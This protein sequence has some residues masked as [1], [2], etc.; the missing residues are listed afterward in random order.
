[1][2]RSCVCLLLA[3]FLAGCPEEAAPPGVTGGGAPDTTVVPDT[4]QRFPGLDGQQQRYFD[5]GNDPA[6]GDPGGGP[7]PGEDAEPGV[8]AWVD[9][10]FGAPCVDNSD[11]D[12]G[13]CVKGPDD[14]YVCTKLCLDECPAGWLCKGAPQTAPDVLFIC[15]FGQ[16]EP[17]EPCGYDEECGGTLDRCSAIGNK[18]ETY[19][20]QH[21]ANAGECPD[22]FTC[23]APAARAGASV[24]QCIPDTN[25][26][27]C[28]AEL[29]QT[30]RICEVLNQFGVCTGT[31]LCDGADGWIGCTAEPPAPE[32]CDGVDN[33]CDGDTDEGFPPEPC[34]IENAYGKCTGVQA[35]TG[36]GGVHCDAAI[37]D[38]ELCDGADNDCDGYTDQGFTDTEGDG[39]ADCVDPDDDDDDVKDAADNCPLK[40]NNAQDDLDTDGVGDLCDDDVDGDGIFNVADNCPKIFNPDQ[41]DLDADTAGD[42]CDPDIDGDGD[43][44]ETDCGPTDPLVSQSGKEACDGKDNDCDGLFDEGFTDTDSDKLGDCIDPDDDNDGEP[45]QTDCEPLDPTVYTGADELCDQKDNDCDDLVDEGFP[46]LDGNGVLDCVETDG[47]G[48]G[49]PDGTDC[50]PLDK[51]IHHAADELCDGLD[52]DCDGLKDEDFPDSDGDLLA[53]CVDADDDNDG[54]PDTSDCAPLD[55]TVSGKVLE[56]CNG[57]DDN[58]NELVDEG[59]PDLDGDGVANCADADDDNDG[60]ADGEDNCPFVKN[61]EQGDNDV[62]GAGDLCDGDDDNDGVDDDVDNCPL[63]ANAPQGDLDGNGEGDACDADD[64]GD[65]TPDSEDCKPKNALVHKGAAEVCDGLDNNCDGAADE[66]FDDSDEDSIADCVDTDDDNDGDPDI[67]DC[68]P[69]DP[70]VSNLSL[71]SCNGKDDNCNGKVDE[72]F[73]DSDLD[74]VPDCVDTDDDDDGDVDASD[75]APTDPDVHHGA[76]EI[77]NGKDDNCEDG[78]DEGFVDSD[79]DKLPDCADDDD[80]NDG[81]PDATDCAPLDQKVSSLILEI[82]DGKDN[83]CNGAADEGFDDTDGDKQADCVDPDDDGDGMEDGADC[84]PKDPKVFGGAKELCDGKDNDCNGKVD[85]GF[86]DSDG[87]G[88]ADCVDADSDNDGDPDVTDCA[89]TDP[90]ISSLLDELC[91]GKDNNCQGGADESFPDTDQDG[92][93]DCVDTDDDND[94]VPDAD[95]NCG[96]IKNPKQV[97]SDGDGQGD[98]CDTDSDNDGV[99]NGADNCVVVFNPGQT[100]TDVDGMGDA[101]DDDDDGDTVVDTADCEPLIA[102]IF[103]GAT[104]LCDDIDNDCDGKVDEGFGDNDDDGQ[105]DCLDPDDDNDGD[106]DNTDCEPLDATVSH[107][108]KEECDNV[109]NNCDGQVDEGFE[110]PDKDGIASCVDHDDDGDGVPDVSDNCSTVKN[111]DQSDI[112]GDGLG[113][114]CDDDD[115]NDGTPDSE[116]CNTKNAAVAPGKAE[117][118]DGIDNDCDGKADEDFPDT[119]KDGVADCLDKDDDGDGDPDVNDCAPLDA[120]ISGDAKEL[121]DGLDNNCNDAIDEGFTD[122]DGDSSPDCLDNDDDNDGD[123]DT[124]DCAPLDSGVHHGAKELCNALDDNCVD[125]VDEGFPSSDADALPDCLDTDDD[126]DGDPDATDC[127]PLNA[128]ISSLVTEACDGKDNNCDGKIDEGFLDTDSDGTADCVDADDDGDTVPDKDDCAPK[129]ATISAKATEVCDGKDNNC[130][131]S[132]DEGFPD[133]DKDGQADCVDLDDDNDGDPDDSDCDDS[134]PAIS[135]VATELCDGKDNNC[136]GK[137]DEGFPNADGDPLADCVDGDDDND[138]TPDDDDNC[139]TKANDQTDTDA[140]GKGDACD[141]DDDNDGLPDPSDNCPLLANPLQK[142]T[143]NDKVGDQCDDDD[144]NDGSKDADDC[145]PLDGAIHPGATEICDGVDQDCDGTVDEGFGNFDGDTLGD[146][147]DPDDDNDLDPDTSDCQPKNPAIHA[148][149]LEVCDGIDQNC[150]GV[151]DDGFPDLNK[152]G[153]ADCV[154]PDDDGDDKLDGDDNCPAVAN[155]DQADN[156][157]DGVGDACDSDDDNDDLPDGTDNCPLV[158]NP[159]QADNDSDKVGDACDPDDDNDGYDDTADCKPLDKNVNPGVVEVCD[160]IDNSCAGVA[161]KGFPDLDKDG[162]ADCVDNDDDGDG[163]PDSNDCK[164]LDNKIYNGAPELCDG[165]DNNCNLQIDE[166]HLDTDGDTIADCVD[167]DDDGDGV[168][169]TEDNCQLVFNPDQV[170]IDEDGI[171]DTCDPKVPGVVTKVVIRDAAK[172]KGSEVGDV[173]VELGETLTLYAA[174]YDKDGLFAGGQAV[175]WSVDG[176]LDAVSAAADE[177][178]ATFAPSTPV[179]SGTIIASPKTAGVKSDTTGTITVN[180]PPP[181]CPADLTKTTIVPQRDSIV[182]DG[183]DQVRVDVVTRD[184]WGSPVDCEGD[185][186]VLESTAGTL[187]ASVTDDGTVYFQNLQSEIVTG[188][189]T[190]SGTL[191]G[192]PITQTATVEFVQPE[193]VVDG[194]ATIDCSNYNAFEGKSILVKDGGTLT[195]LCT[196]E[197]PLM[198]FGSFFIKHGTL[199]T[200]KG[201]RINIQVDEMFIDKKGVVTVAQMGPTTGLATPPDIAS[202]YEIFG[203]FTDPKTSGRAGCVDNNTGYPGGLLRIKVVGSGKFTL[204]GV[205]DANAKLN[206]SSGCYAGKPSSF[207][208]YLGSSGGRVKISAKSL[209]GTGTITSRGNKGKW[210]PLYQPGNGGVISLVDFE[211]RS[212]SFA[213]PAIYSQLHARPGNGAT[214][215]PGAAPGIVYLRPKGQKYGDIIMGCGTGGSHAGSAHINTVPEATVTSVTSN[216]IV[217]SGAGWPVDRYVGLYVNPNIAQGNV[218]DKSDDV[219]FRVVKNT[220]DTLFLDGNPTGV[221]SAGDTLRGILPVRNLEIRGRATFQTTGD[222]MVAEGDLHSGDTVTFEFEG[223]FKAKDLDL[224]S[225]EAIKVSGPLAGSATFGSPL[226]PL[227]ANL[228]Y[229]QILRGGTDDFTFN[230]SLASQARLQTSGQFRAGTLDLTGNGKVI[231]ETGV[232]VNSTLS[233]TGGHIESKG[234][235]VINGPV[236]IASFGGH[237]SIKVPKADWA[238]QQLKLNGVSGQVDLGATKIELPKVD[239][240][241]ATGFKLACYRGS[242]NQV[243]CSSSSRLE[244]ETLSR[245]GDDSYAFDMDFYGV[246]VLGMAVLYARD[247]TF[248]GGFQKS[249]NTTNVLTTGAIPMPNGHLNISGHDNTKISVGVESGTGAI[250]AKSVSVTAGTHIATSLTAATTVVIGSTFDVG[251]VAAGGNMTVDVGGFLTTESLSTSADLFVQ[252]TSTITH[253]PA[254]DTTVY[255][256]QI[257]AKSATIAT[258]SNINLNRRGFQQGF[259]VGNTTTGGATGGV[260][261]S[262]GGLGGLGLAGGTAPSVFDDPEAPLLPGGGGGGPLSYGGGQLEMTLTGTLTVNGV[263]MANGKTIHEGG[264]AGGAIWIKGAKTITGGGGGLISAVGGDAEDPVSGGGGG[265]RIALTGYTTLSGNFAPGVLDANI[266]VTGGTGLNDGGDGTIHLKPAP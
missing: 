161:D 229:E 212:G 160:G 70:I 109:D 265:G 242:T 169:D 33:D 142:D 187:V 58:C 179:T 72:G 189:A 76:V 64:D 153:Q 185:V 36:E 1:M 4:E 236:A 66:G 244:V 39:I 114:A 49:D 98:A 10:G 131:G 258:G 63:N 149:A 264:G 180:A 55:K 80:D 167:P 119:D 141:P 105:G 2:R 68:A 12:S 234:D 221:A 134:N 18:G 85:D 83:N 42:L 38:V 139:P 118:C 54:D 146:C 102:A 197:C 74:T 103:P 206:Y 259:T 148:S 257:S 225:V 239:F 69:T 115:D 125:G 97:D 73:P 254:S 183:I 37:P 77:C 128:N 163:D 136:N 152:D 196:D 245:Q 144:D 241:A 159:S 112:D 181:T 175:T 81:D 107:F 99:G 89:P 35:C 56:S 260:G 226:V 26:C 40:A 14:K 156:D 20:T 151:K 240:G 164:P 9:K 203:D 46:D 93:A 250:D 174:G 71:E 7:G 252:G 113:D 106:P 50:A 53:D 219:L 75:C 88:K 34:V 87:D 218:K 210:S 117:A 47:D 237:S 224:G 32:A 17:C 261:G 108:A 79:G 124:S 222:I 162:T 195:I 207:Q 198:K 255:G 52:N 51:T 204:D 249:S 120:A 122:S 200:T 140:D 6:P 16:V 253:P 22:G 57:A 13:F 110:D 243:W 123:P 232:L 227:T 138:G 247:L 143:D 24:H 65:G 173:T 8:D 43:P 170:D 182:A 96:V 202:P 94:S 67:S 201:N 41:S 95:D 61:P 199:T 208:L 60:I 5:S 263:I 129:D 223:G 176:S 19:C 177:K 30:T 150:N 192:Q 215:S 205:I 266:L 44:N 127:A 86:F 25:S 188:T 21:C 233:M 78:I 147:V 11:C 23:T 28:T 214:F 186:V 246:D 15:I 100:D 84:A 216:A 101:C 194:K 158:V 145:K 230:V 59:F 213:E 135:S 29:D 231:A 209:A 126:N 121:C 171:G 238:G 165:V 235:I 133:T 104:E 48:D 211:T 45:D 166:G 62:D 137:K 31:E 190:I 132:K 184:L 157:D 251:S 154:D 168:P 217:S 91:D 193:L 262:H 116:D 92:T 130:N 256:L 111:A 3:L 178:S 191:N 90:A 27:E 172:G 155:P 82:C 248:V 228:V 220:E